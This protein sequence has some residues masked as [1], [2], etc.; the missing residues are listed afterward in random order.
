MRRSFAPLLSMVAALILASAAHAQ[1]DAPVWYVQYEVIMKVDHSATGTGAM[2]TTTTTLRME[3][4]FAGTAK[5]DMRN[6]GQ[7][8]SMDMSSFDAEKYKNMTTAEQLKVSQQMMDAMQYAANWMPGPLE[9]GDEPDAM[10]NHMLAVSVP[11]RFT[12][13]CTTTGN[14]LSDETGGKYDYFA[15]STATAS[16]GKAYLGDQI[17][18]EMDTAKKKYWLM[19]PFGY[20][21][22][23]AERNDVKWVRVKKYRPAGTT[24]W[25]DEERKTDDASL[26][27]I[28]DQIKFDSLPAN[29]QLPVIVGTLDP[30]ATTITGEKAFAGHLAGEAIP[31]VPVTLT[32]KYT[33]STTPPAEAAAK[34]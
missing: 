13:D 4:A 23:N 10:M 15:Q 28:G 24:A 8:L 18:F 12:Y 16:G 22:L 25:G 5:L 31:D 11:V 34:K 7:V 29:S 3:R 32:F 9:V 2:G 14:N 26:D 33:V 17:K 20:T 1:F 21:D 30:S 6:M 19:L 27:T